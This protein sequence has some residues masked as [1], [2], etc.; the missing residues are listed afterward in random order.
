MKHDL[1]G[2]LRRRLVV[3]WEIKLNTVE[4]MESSIVETVRRKY[5]ELD[6]F[7]HVE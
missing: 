4:G 7:A 5:A 6:R 3:S 2:V 1:V